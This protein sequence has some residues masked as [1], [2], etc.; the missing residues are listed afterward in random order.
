MRKLSPVLAFAVLLT[1]CGGGGGGGGGTPP[2]GEPTTYYVRASGSDENDGLSPETAFRNISHAASRVVQAGDTVYV[3]PGEY[4]S[5]P[6]PEGPSGTAVDIAGIDGTAGAPLRFIADPTGA[7][8][9]DDPGDV[10]VDANDRPTAFR[11]SRSPFVTIDGFVI[12]NAKGGDEAS[13]IQA[14]SK[15]AN[16]TVRNCTITGNVN[17]IRVQDS[18]DALIFNNLI[19]DNQGAGVF[20]Q[21]G[22]QRARILSNT[23]ADNGR[24]GI[25]VGG[26]ANQDGEASIDATVRNNIVQN[27]SNVNIL[28]EEDPP[29]SSLPG[30]SGNYNVVFAPGFEDQLKTYRPQDIR[31][32]ND[33][34]ADAA[35]VDPAAGDYHLDHSL[36]PA[37]DTGNG[38][39]EGALVS[40]L[41]ARTTSVDGTLDEAPLDIGYHYPAPRPTP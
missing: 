34:N 22:S 2:P 11:I 4:R 32:E 12:R 18:N 39:V 9:G 31:G 6:P 3:G 25:R 17:A 8:T 1:G 38:A 16:L 23:I 15:S 7:Q 13:A 40:Q 21:S 19:V 5:P 28:V 20:I 30:Y 26:T 41:F 27:N 35:F 10:I 29:P 24:R 36:S 33:I 14:R 37:V